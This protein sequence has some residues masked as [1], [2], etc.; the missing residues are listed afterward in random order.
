MF[1]EHFAPT[2]DS[3]ITLSNIKTA[4][5]EHLGL[6]SFEKRASLIA[7]YPSMLSSW[8]NTYVLCAFNRLH[9]MCQCSRFEQNKDTPYS[10]GEINTDDVHI[11]TAILLL[12]DN[13]PD[14]KGRDRCE[15][16]Q[17]SETKSTRE[18]LTL[19]K[20]LMALCKRPGMLKS[21]LSKW[22]KESRLVKTVSKRKRLLHEVES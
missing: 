3:A 1:D 21:C 12:Y 4:T 6:L 15:I 9:D 8:A 16:S 17:L 14:S 22:H 5:A 2:L 7:D 10:G 19:V 18:I 13:A 11:R 20:G